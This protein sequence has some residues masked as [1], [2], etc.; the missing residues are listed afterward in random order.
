[1][2]VLPALE[3]HFKDSKKIRTGSEWMDLAK[4]FLD[5]LG[6]VEPLVKYSDTSNLTGVN[7]TPRVKNLIDLH[8]LA[9]DRRGYNKEEAI[10]DV[11]EGHKRSLRG[12]ARMSDWSK[13][14]AITR[15]V[16]LYMYKSDRALVAEELESSG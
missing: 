12:G 5:E 13:V 9:M 4:T 3:A 7:C 16:D 1:M 15:N 10:L 8:A 2:E 14:P 6:V 11:S